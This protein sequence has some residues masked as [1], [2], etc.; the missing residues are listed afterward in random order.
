M[1]QTT[2]FFSEGESPT[3]SQGMWL[4]FLFNLKN[5]YIRTYF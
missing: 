5:L 4:I 3:L 2:Q 1:K